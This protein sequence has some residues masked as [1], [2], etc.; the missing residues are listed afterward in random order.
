[1]RLVLLLALTVCGCEEAPIARGCVETVTVVGPGWTTST[2]AHCA[3][4]QTS[5]T[6]PA[7]GGMFLVTCRCAHRLGE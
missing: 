3:K 1:M 4:D 2:Y 7:A 6:A 5:E